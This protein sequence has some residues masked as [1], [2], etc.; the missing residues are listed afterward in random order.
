MQEAL[1][2]SNPDDAKKPEEIPEHERIKN[3]GNTFYKS[4]NFEEAL[5]CYS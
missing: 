5:K 4:K 3:N 2:L 1:N